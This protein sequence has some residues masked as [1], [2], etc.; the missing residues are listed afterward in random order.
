MGNLVRKY[1]TKYIVLLSALVAVLCMALLLGIW[2]DTRLDYNEGEIRVQV[3]QLIY[4]L[5]ENRPLDKNTLSYCIFNQDGQVLQSTMSRYK[6]GSSINMHTVGTM[7]NYVVPITLPDQERAL[8]YVDVSNLKNSSAIHI[9]II[10]TICVIVFASGV[11]I[12]L[13]HIRR[14]F[15]ENMIKPI[16]QLHQAT[17]EIISGNLE[18]KVEYDYDGE[19]GELC[20]DFEQMRDQISDSYQRELKLREKVHVMYASISHD[21]KTP[22]ATITGYLENIIYDVVKEPE[23]I[24]TCAH[25]ML[26]KSQVLNKL[27]DDILEHAKAELNDLSIEKKEVYSLSYFQNMMSGYEA[28]AKNGGYQFSYD[29]PDNYIIIL[30]PDRISEVFQ[31]IIGNAIKYGGKAVEIQV[32]FE[33][34]KEQEPALLISIKDNGPGID[35]ADLPFIFDVFYRGNKARTQN[36][37]GSGLGLN[38]SKYIIEEHGG[39]IACDSIVGVGTTI[40]F[41][42]P[43]Q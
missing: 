32:H 2:T 9:K 41:S 35:A 19:V 14:Q 25:R 26:N 21:L 18:Q 6:I 16:R 29:L 10:L 13:V 22:L 24:K 43:L 33:S 12:L 28:D 7:Q 4:T 1:I 40:S 39:Q 3:N 5:E 20:H 37:P 38:I 17:R 23:Q 34:I 8:L 15:I 27:I 42:I 30:D 36:V 11:V 31:N